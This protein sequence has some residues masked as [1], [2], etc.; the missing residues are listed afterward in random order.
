MDCA[1]A[2]RERRRM[3]DEGTIEPLPEP[4]QSAAHKSYAAT[5]RKLRDGLET[6]VK[7]Y[8]DSANPDKKRLHQL[9]LDSQL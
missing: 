8:A 1:V 4:S 3:L 7:S 9:W 2:M 5:V 6:V